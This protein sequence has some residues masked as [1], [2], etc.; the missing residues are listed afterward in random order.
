M[1]IATV[2]LSIIG[3]SAGLV[4]ASRAEDPPR[5]GATSAPV[6]AATTSRATRTADAPACRDETQDAGQLL[7]AAGTLTQVLVL[8]TRTSVVYICRDEAGSLYYH[9]NNG[10]NIWIENETALFLPDVTPLGDEYRAVAGDGAI[11]TVSR[12]RL[13][14]VHPDGRREEQPAR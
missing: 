7:G 4:L 6:T 3:I 1:V 2:F 11:F 8:R 5:A 9:A 10:G 13:L 14:I 12:K